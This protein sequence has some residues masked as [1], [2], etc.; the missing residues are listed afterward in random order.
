MFSY[1]YMKSSVTSWIE[2]CFV[3]SAVYY[4]FFLQR[5]NWTVW[6]IGSNL[7]HKVYLTIY[8]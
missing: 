3:K 1:I 4:S 2:K 8:G 6:T 7:S 5:L